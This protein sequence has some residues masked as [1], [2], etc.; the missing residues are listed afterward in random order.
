M[1]GLHRDVEALYAAHPAG[2]ERDGARAGLTAAARARIAALPLANRDPAALADAV[3]LNDACLALSGT[4]GGELERY[5]VV[6]DSL[7][8]D[9]PAFVARFRAAADSDDPADALLGR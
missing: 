3:R 8:G 9:L 6:L 2:P 1:V 5:Q 4:Y 7:R